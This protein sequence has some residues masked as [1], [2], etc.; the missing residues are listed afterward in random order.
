VLAYVID[1]EAVGTSAAPGLMLGGIGFAIGGVVLLVAGH[2]FNLVL[3]ILEP[4][5]Q[6]ARLIYVEHFSKYLH[7]GGRLFTPFKG[8]RTHTTSELELMDKKVPE[9]VPSGG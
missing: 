8:S 7:G 9:P 4:G 3:G 6:G 2:M 1:K 5:I